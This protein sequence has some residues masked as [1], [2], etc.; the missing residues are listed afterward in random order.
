MLI[1]FFEI[2]Q[3][4]KSRNAFS[5]R[6]SH[7]NALE[8]NKDWTTSGVNLD[9]YSKKK[10]HSKE[11]LL[12]YERFLIGHIQLLFMFLFLTLLSPL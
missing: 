8:T 6:A 5:E 3:F 7:K 11:I 4:E 10:I 12:I 2:F 9:T 1:S